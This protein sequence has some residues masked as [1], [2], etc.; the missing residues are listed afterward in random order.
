M[1]I[2][3]RQ[4][5]WVVLVPIATYIPSIINVAHR[6]LW[7]FDFFVI[8]QSEQICKWG[9]KYAHPVMTDHVGITCVP[10]TRIPSL[11]KI[12]HWALIYRERGLP[13][14]VDK[15][16][17]TYIHQS[18][19]TYRQR[20]KWKLVVL[21]HSWQPTKKRKKIMFV[22]SFVE[23]SFLFLSYKWEVIFWSMFL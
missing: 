21:Q 19:H 3:W 14:D 18:V 1:H 5:T 9:T 2:W 11:T 22:V 20:Y 16:W 6:E 4:T 15:I 8:S 23:R 7:I 12:S 10:T 17:H 13:F